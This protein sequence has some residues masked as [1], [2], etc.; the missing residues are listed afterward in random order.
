MEFIRIKN[1]SSKYQKQ[2]FKL[3]RILIIFI[4][5]IN[6][7]MII[8]QNTEAQ[9]RVL[10]T[11]EFDRSFRAANVKPGE[12]IPVNFY[13]NVSIDRKYFTSKVQFVEAY[14]TV[15]Y[16]GDGW[17]A[18]I[19]TP[20]LILTQRINKEPFVLSVLAPPQERHEATKMINVTGKWRVIPS[21]N[22]I[23]TEGDI[24]G[25]S[26]SVYV[27][28]FYRFT[29]Y[30]DPPLKIIWPTEPADFDLIIYNQG[31]GVDKF[32]IKVVNE[33]SLLKSGYVVNL[34]K[35]SIDVGPK[36]EGR[37]KV[38][39]IGPE[40]LFTPWKIANTRVIISA[41]SEGAML[42]ENREYIREAT[43]FYYE[44]G[45]YVSP[46]VWAFLIFLIILISFIYYRYRKKYKKLFDKEKK[47]KLKKKLI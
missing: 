27:N 36:R 9:A 31:N 16:P 14:L 10:A 37:V 2:I 42:N 45:P 3:I 20:Y 46:P 24:H 26:V 35:T 8:P 15:E 30:E 43:L 33:D 22:N 25:A 12:N 23:I 41:Q 13:G 6:I 38:T 5:I 1:R 29:V 4:I 39:V 19:S 17:A 28:Q 40:P 44:N 18:Q 32:N 21:G 7:F 34:N 47:E 11:I